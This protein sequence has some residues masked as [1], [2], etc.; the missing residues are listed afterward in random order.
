MKKTLIDRGTYRIIRTNGTEETVGEKPT[1][2]KVLAALQCDSLDTVPLERDRATGLA[3]SVMIVDDFGI[4]KNLPRNMRAT[5]L[6][7][8]VRPTFAHEILGDA[9]VCDDRDFV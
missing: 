5:E 2:R 7:R 1:I 8:Q 4:I 3:Q 6:V 9:V